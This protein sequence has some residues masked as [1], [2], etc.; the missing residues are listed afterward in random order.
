[1]PLVAC[2]PFLLAYA[3]LASCGGSDTPT[4]KQNEQLNRAENML[5]EA[6]NTLSGIDENRL[7]DSRSPG[8]PETRAVEPR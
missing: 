1:M 3:I 2:G 8:G 4:A 7:D 5:D 6:P